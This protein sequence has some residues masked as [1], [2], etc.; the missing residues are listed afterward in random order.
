M[1]WSTYSYWQRWPSLHWRGPRLAQEKPAGD[2]A[3]KLPSISDK[4]KGAQKLDGFM[5]LYWQPASGKLFMEISRFK[6]ETAVPGVVACRPRIEPGRTRS[7]SARR[8]HRRLLRAHRPEGA[9]DRAQLPIP[10]HHQ[11]CGRTAGGGRL[12]RPI[13]PLG[14]QGRGRGQ[15]PRARGRDRI[16]HARRARRRR[17][18]AAGASRAVPSRRQ[19]AARCSCREQRGSRRTPRSKPR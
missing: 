11:R 13:G 17:P 7:R 8:L 9:A 1:K 4:T 19:R 2:S 18:A 3:D 16:L 10:R 12:L 5:P 15:W 14:I 6:Q